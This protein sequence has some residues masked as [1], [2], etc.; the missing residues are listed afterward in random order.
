MNMAFFLLMSLPFS[1][2]PATAD[3]TNLR[4]PGFDSGSD[5]R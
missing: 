3:S 4:Y 2:G 1:F 5:Y